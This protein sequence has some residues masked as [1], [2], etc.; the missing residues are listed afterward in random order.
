MPNRT[1]DGVHTLPCGTTRGGGA[2]MNWAYKKRPIDR[3]MIRVKFLTGRVIVGQYFDGFV[4]VSLQDQPRLEPWHR[5][6]YVSA[7]E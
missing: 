4:W 1:L 5:W 7:S 2:D 6:E 3:Q